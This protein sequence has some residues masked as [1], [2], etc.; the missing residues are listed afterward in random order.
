MKPYIICHMLS[1]LDGKIDGAALKAVMKDGE[2]E[3]TGA[4]LKGDAWIC[5][6]T[7]M[8]QHFA[9]AEPFVSHSGKTAGPQ[10]VHVARAASSYAIT[11]DTLGKLQWSGNDI[12]GDHLICV[13]SE[14]VPEDYLTMLRNR[15]VSYIVS[16]ESSVDLPNAVALLGQHFKIRTLLLEGGGHINGAFL[17]AG[18]IDEVS[19]LIV[20]GVDG[21]HDIPAVF[22]GVN[23][24][25]ETAVP[26]KLKSVEQRD[27]D[28]LWIRYEVV[29]P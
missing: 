11:V 6:R 16:G 13:L 19:L 28:A 5:G 22:D 7:T 2:Y 4:L 1:S 23:P 3:A 18:L 29:R 21:R 26:L 20:P 12:D 27:N 14:R 25:H 17:A 15:G 9:E 8:Q 24:S 10:P